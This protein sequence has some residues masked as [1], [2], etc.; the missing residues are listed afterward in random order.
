MIHVPPPDN[1]IALTG[2]SGAAYF[3]KIYS[4]KGRSGISGPAIVCLTNSRYDNDTWQHQVRDIYQTD[5]ARE[6]FRQF[7]RRD[8]IDNLMLITSASDD[9]P[10]DKVRDLI[11]AYVHK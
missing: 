8:D 6:A 5:D 4:R 9:H 10:E 11:E 3:G 7:K 1:A 2:K